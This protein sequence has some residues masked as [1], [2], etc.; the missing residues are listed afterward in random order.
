MPT[1]EDVFLKL[2]QLSKHSKENNYDE[3]IDYLN[4]Q[5]INNNIIYDENN[6]IDRKDQIISKIIRCL[7]VS[8]NKRLYQIIREKKTF[9]I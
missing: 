8:F 3:D 1:L 9:I 7:I 6:Y 4:R 2:S 5:N